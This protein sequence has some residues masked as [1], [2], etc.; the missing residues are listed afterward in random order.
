VVAEGRTSASLVSERCPRLS[1]CEV[2]IRCCIYNVFII[3]GSSGGCE[4]VL[5]RVDIS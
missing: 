3:P 4:F 1:S 2:G 5:A